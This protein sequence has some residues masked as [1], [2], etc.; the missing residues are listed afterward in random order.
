M[1]LIC[2]VQASPMNE[3]ALL[4]HTGPCSEYLA[5]QMNFFV[6]TAKRH[7]KIGKLSFQDGVAA[8]VSSDNATSSGINAK[9]GSGALMRCTSST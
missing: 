2:D 1:N 8:S 7:R 4:S 3:K 5:R 9:C 6:T